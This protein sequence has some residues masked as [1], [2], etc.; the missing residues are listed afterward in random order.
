LDFLKKNIVFGFGLNKKHSIFLS[1]KPRS[2][3]NDS[4][5]YTL[6]QFQRLKNEKRVISKGQNRKK[7]PIP[8][9]K[10]LFSSLPFSGGAFL[11]FSLHSSS[12]ASHSN[13]NHLLVS[14]IIISI[15]DSDTFIIM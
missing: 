8:F 2:Q 6:E 1:N 5:A 10:P 4:P 14:S 15:L 13:N 9:L 11:S 3:R 12:H 7:T